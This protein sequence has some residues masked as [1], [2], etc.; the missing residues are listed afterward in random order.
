M[1]EIKRPGL[2]GSTLKLIA[3]ITMFIDHS[4]AT[5]IPALKKLPSIQADP[6]LIRQLTRLYTLMRKVGRLAFPIFCFLLVEGFVHTRSVR[7]YAQR[8]LLF[9]LIS[10]FAFDFALKTG[11]FFPGKQNVYWTLLIGL[12][13]LW[14]MAEAF[15]MP[16]IQIA[17]C[18]AGLLAADLLKT[19]YSYKGVFLIEILYFFRCTRLYQC[20]AGAAAISWEAFAPFAFIPVFFY[21]GKRGLN[22][23]YFFYW[24]YPAHL[25]L[26]GILSKMIIPQFA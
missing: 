10:E 24:F 17:I 23:K 21:N 18:A 2:S 9:A 6:E 8:M 14:G 16:V 11:W 22:L 3:I 12:L 7:K 26:L 25:I 4:A 15:G 19:D 5:V 1:F 13:V 20:L